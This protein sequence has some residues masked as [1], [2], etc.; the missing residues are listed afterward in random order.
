[1]TPS[2]AVDY[3]A[4]KY[5][6]FLSIPTVTKWAIEYEFGHQ[7]GGKGGK[8]VINKTKFKNYLTGKNEDD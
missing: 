4:E 3:A 7:L 6:I 5:K 2:Q 1:M 8:W